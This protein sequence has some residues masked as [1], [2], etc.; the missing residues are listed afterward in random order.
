MTTR[1]LTLL[2]AAGCSAGGPAAP[3]AS[4]GQRAAPRAFLRTPP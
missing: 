4:K 3:A 2:V 1:W